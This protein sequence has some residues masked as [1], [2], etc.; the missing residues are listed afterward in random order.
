MIR[1]SEFFLYTPQD[2]RA[3]ELCLV[4]GLRFPEVT[5]WIRAT[6]DDYR[7]VRA[8][9]LRET[10]ILASISDYHVYRKLGSDRAT[11]L[12]GY[13]RV[14][15]AALADGGVARGH[16]EGARRARGL[17]LVRALAGRPIGPGR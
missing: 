9:G 13:G 10:G 6:L 14:V 1:Q 12:D 17:G 11:V 7:L 2:R 16:L 3:V 8:A 15:E 5:G 4:K